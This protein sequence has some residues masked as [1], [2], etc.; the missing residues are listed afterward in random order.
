VGEAGPSNWAEN[1]S[2]AQGYSGPY[3]K[4]RSLSSTIKNDT[5]TEAYKNNKR[6]KDSDT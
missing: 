2:T 6:R 5:I 4:K 3:T 1:N